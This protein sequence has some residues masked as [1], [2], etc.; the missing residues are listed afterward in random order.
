[1]LFDMVKQGHPSIA[2]L[3]ISPRTLKLFLNNMPQVKICGF[4]IYANSVP[5]KES[6]LN[7]SHHICSIVNAHPYNNTTTSL[8]P[9]HY[10]MSQSG[11]VWLG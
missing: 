6:T 10:F 9:N 8:I 11:S 2:S 3:G 4:V 5:T 1:M 7:L